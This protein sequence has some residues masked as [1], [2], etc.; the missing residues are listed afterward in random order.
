METYKNK[1]IVITGGCGFIGSQLAALLVSLKSEVTI[2]DN[3][4]SGTEKNIAAIKKK[5][6]FIQG[7][8]T[9]LDL[10][11]QAIE[12]QELIFHLAAKISVPELEHNP[13]AAFHN[14]IIG[15]QNVLYASYKNSV[16]KIFFAS[17]AAVYGTQNGASQETADCNP[18]S[19]YGYSKLIGELLCKQ[20]SDLYKIPILCGRFFNVWGENQDGS[21][22]TSSFMAR[23]NYCI[24]N[25][26]PITLYGDGNQTRDFIHV[27][28][29]VDI[30]LK[31]MLPD[32]SKFYQVVNIA[33]GIRKRLCDIIK[34]KM[35]ENKKYNR[36]IQFCPERLGDIKNSYADCSLLQ[37]LL[38]NSLR[39][40]NEK[41]ST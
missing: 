1:K 18:L 15:T 38:S 8:I 13:Q 16:K 23:L 4:S 29:I 17:S 37:K 26:L 40:S 32:T 14:N 22:P 6:K 41:D 24:A 7:D 35:E 34:D 28:Q 36:T 33:T 25:N 20:Y 5:I 30:I 3:L 27:S 9:D 31:L 2:I 39:Y 11:I 19:T 21:Y 12:S 10:C